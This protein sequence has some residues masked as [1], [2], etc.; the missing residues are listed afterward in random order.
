MEDMGLNK[1]AV[2]GN[3]KK[4]LIFFCLILTSGIVFSQTILKY[5]AEDGILSGLEISNEN[6]VNDRIN[7]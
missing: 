6:P 4:V 2:M 1:I 7:L 3:L 5:E